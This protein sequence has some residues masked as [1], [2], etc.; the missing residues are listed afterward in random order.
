[1]ILN[2]VT[3][4]DIDVWPAFV[5]TAYGFNLIPNS[6]YKR[7]EKRNCKITFHDAIKSK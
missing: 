4:F 2:G 7:F 3:R 5:K 6:L 1:M